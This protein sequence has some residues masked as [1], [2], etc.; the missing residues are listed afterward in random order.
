MAENDGPPSSL[1]SGARPPD[2]TVTGDANLGGTRSGRGR[3]PRWLSRPLARWLMAGILV[4]VGIPLLLV[5]DSYLIVHDIRSLAR[6]VPDETRVMRDRLSDPRTP[7]PLHHQWVDLGAMSPHL[8]HAVVVHEDA[9]FY[10]HRGFD[11]FEIRAALRRSWSERRMVRGA[12]TITTQLAR[13]LYLGTGR[14]LLRK[15]RE[16]P[17]PAIRN[18]RGACDGH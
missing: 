18:T 1:G 2:P 3:T 5:A 17:C 6:E 8:I 7:R 14:S 16:I 4:L 13:N 15:I 10:E 9:T 11:T 12:S